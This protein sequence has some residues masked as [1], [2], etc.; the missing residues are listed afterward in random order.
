[1]V[2]NAYPQRQTLTEGP[3]E[4][5]IALA[6]PVRHQFWQHLV[7]GKPPWFR[8]SNARMVQLCDRIQARHAL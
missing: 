8:Q 5:G 1:M 3:M 4:E 2:A 6:N 7:L